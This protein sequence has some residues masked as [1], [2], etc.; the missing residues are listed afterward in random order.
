[1]TNF[2]TKE[3]SSLFFQLAK[4]IVMVLVYCSTEQLFVLVCN[5]VSSVEIEPTF[6]EEMS[7]EY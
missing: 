4:S 3:I 6:H 7:S 2:A 1:M 5:T